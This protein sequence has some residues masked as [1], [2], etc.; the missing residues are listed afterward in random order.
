[1]NNPNRDLLLLFNQE[2]MS[3]QALEQ[4]VE[5]LHGLLYDVEKIESLVVAHELIDLKRYKIINKSQQ[6][7]T[8]FR[9][10][11]LQPFEFLNCKN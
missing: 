8:F 10:R 9:K 6:L 4:E 3:P 2:I 11:E 7:R 1:M 5:F